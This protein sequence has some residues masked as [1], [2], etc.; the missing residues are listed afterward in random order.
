VI[1]ADWAFGPAVGAPCEK[2]VFERP[3]PTT[4]VA[5]SDEIIRTTVC[6]MFC[7]AIA[8][9][10]TE[11][12]LSTIACVMPA[13][14]AGGDRNWVGVAKFDSGKGIFLAALPIAK[15]VMST[16]L[17]VGGPAT[18]RAV[19]EQG[20]SHHEEWRPFAQPWRPHQD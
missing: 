17:M 16:G 7:P 19:L 13:M 18:E 20:W 6:V 10:R 8:A 14:S 11:F 2:A 9:D 12:G 1:S 4:G 15:G 5:G 3:P